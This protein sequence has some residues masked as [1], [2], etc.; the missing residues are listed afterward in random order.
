MLKNIEEQKTKTKAILG[1]II[2]EYYDNFSERSNAPKFT[3]NVIERLMVEQQARIR[4]ALQESNSELVSSVITEE[5]KM[6]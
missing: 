5:K 3:I 2:D 6:S 4:E 1:K